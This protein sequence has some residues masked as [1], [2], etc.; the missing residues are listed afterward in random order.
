LLGFA[1]ALLT[2][3]GCSSGTNPAQLACSDGGAAANAVTMTCGG[4]TN[5]TTEQVDVVMGGPASGSTTL[6][7]LNFDVTYVTSNLEFVPA[8]SFTSPLFP[9]ALVAVTLFNGQQGRVVVSIQQ[10][11]GL[12]DVAVGADP[13]VV[14]SLSFRSVAGVTFGSTALTFAN[15]E[16]TAASTAISF[17]SGLAL[18]YQ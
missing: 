9:G 18:S 15:A 16:T 17:L 7:G 4:A 5:S 3:F 11:G 1:A 14:L 13:Q 6:R 12:P 10:P 2:A 8:A